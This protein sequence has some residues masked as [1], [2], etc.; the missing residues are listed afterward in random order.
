MKTLLAAAALIFVLGVVGMAL[1]PWYLLPAVSFAVGAALRTRTPGAMFGAGLVAGA[2]LWA[3]GALWYGLSA[4]ELPALVAE[5]FGVGSALTLGAVVALAGG[6]TAGL[7]ALLGAY[8]RAVVQ[9][10]STP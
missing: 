7:F 1:G 8:S 2:A 9:G 4:G 5:L 6:L 3:G 10:C